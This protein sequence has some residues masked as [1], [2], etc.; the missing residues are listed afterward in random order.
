MENYSSMKGYGGYNYP[1]RHNE[2]DLAGH[3][4]PV[5]SSA[6]PVVSFQGWGFSTHNQQFDANYKGFGAQNLNT[7][8][9]TFIEE[10]KEDDD[11]ERSVHLGSEYE[12]G[13]RNINYPNNF[14]RSNFDETEKMPIIPSQNSFILNDERTNSMMSHA[15]NKG[16]FHGANIMSLA[17]PISNVKDYELI[18]SDL[19]TKSIKVLIIDEQRGERNAELIVKIRKQL[20]QN[21][22]RMTFL[23][24]LTE[25]DNPLFLYSKEIDE[26]EFQLIRKNQGIHIEFHKFAEYCIVLFDNLN[27]ISMGPTQNEHQYCTFKTNLNN[28]AQFLIQKRDMYRINNQLDL[29]F[30]EATEETKLKYLS[31]QVKEFK[32]LSIKVTEDRDFRISQVNELSDKLQHIG[33]YFRV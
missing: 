23:L 27:G 33:K 6:K 9:N 8:K 26:S 5:A 13:H 4:Q 14:N 24:E 12:F 16:S 21:T 2:A 11:F 22:Q 1:T 28:H 7:A 32:N 15:D 17:K 18:V 3:A 30:N 29:I 20:D 25:E 10:K 19:Y 31:K